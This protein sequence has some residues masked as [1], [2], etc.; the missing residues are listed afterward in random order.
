MTTLAAMMQ[1]SL[2]QARFVLLGSACLL[3]GLQL[4]IVG[5]ASA[6]EQ[7]S[8]F[9]R[10]SELVPAF[11]QRGLGTKAMILATFKGT[12]AFGYFH[13]IVVVLVSVLAIYLT[14]EVAHEVEAG[15][16]DLELA[17][18]VPRHVLV[19]RSLLAA[20]SAVLLVAV[21]MAFGTAVGLRAFSADGFDAPSASVRAMLLAHLVAVAG[22]FGA[23]GLAIAAG[24]RR[25][26]TAFFTTTL[27]AIGLYLLDFLSIGWPMM[28][29]LSWISPFHYYP[30]L[31]IIAGDAAPIRNFSVLLTATVGLSAVGYWRFQRRDL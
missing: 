9:S 18:A 25:W 11:L 30:A 27:A 6:I 20:G 17:R 14:T 31:S 16:V 1:R 21:L 22:L 26:S 24:A 12:V 19:T 5:Q 8:S 2:S 23:L 15:L 28:R 13:P 29:S 7:Q 10:M 3:W 4:V